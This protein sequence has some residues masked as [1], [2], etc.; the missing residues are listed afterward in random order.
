[1]VPEVEKFVREAPK[2]GLAVSLHAADNTLRERIMPINRK[3]PLE[4]LMEMLRRLPLPRR[5]MITFEYVLLG[6]E[7]DSEQDALALARLLHGTKGKV[8]LIHYNPWPGSPHR[9]SSGKAAER[10]M[11]ILTQKGYTVSLRR[12]R[13]EDI[14]AACGQ[15]ALKR[16]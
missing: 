7:N 5:R 12:S 10:F 4:E 2:V 1:L 11:E 6:G 14:L 9:S 8:N 16:K 15:L 3:Y 13:G